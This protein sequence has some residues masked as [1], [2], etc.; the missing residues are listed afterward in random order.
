MG[1]RIKTYKDFW[2][3]YL[4]EHSKP[5]TRTAHIAGTLAGIGVA[6]ATLACGFGWVAL[7]GLGVAYG[8][9]WTAHAFIEKNT[10]ATFKYPLWS[11][12]SDVKMLGHWATGTLQ[13]EVDKHVKAAPAARAASRPA[14]AV[15][16][17][18][19]KWGQSLAG[20]KARFAQAVYP[21]KQTPP[22]HAVKSQ[23]VA[24][25]PKTGG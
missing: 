23:S 25:S 1:E 24:S 6:A 22:T 20:L 8:A 3:F 7:A 17:L 16:G 18:K 12:M 15:K 21:Q 4:S 9:A 5:A 13:R 14:S 10:P 2:P 11:L 19:K